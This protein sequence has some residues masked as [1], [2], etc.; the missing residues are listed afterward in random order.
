MRID[1]IVGEYNEHGLMPRVLDVWDEYTQED[2]PEGF[3]EAQAKF[4]NQVSSQAGDLGA[5][6]TLSVSIPDKVM[7]DLFIT[8]IRPTLWKQVDR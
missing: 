8:P 2:N 5:V 1:L 3:S 7:E 6:R 4:L